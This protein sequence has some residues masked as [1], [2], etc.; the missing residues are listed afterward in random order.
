MGS[1]SLTAVFSNLIRIMQ[2]FT[3]A[4]GLT[5]YFVL[6]PT[7][8]RYPEYPDVVPIDAGFDPQKGIFCTGD[9]PVQEMR[10]VDGDVLTFAD[11]NKRNTERGKREEAVGGT[12]L[13]V[14][15]NAILMLLQRR[16]NR[17]TLRELQAVAKVSDEQIQSVEQWMLLK[18]FT[19]ARPNES[20]SEY[21]ENHPLEEVDNKH[22]RS[23]VREWITQK[24]PHNKQ[25]RVREAISSTLY[26][27]L[28]PHMQSM[29][30]GHDR[31][32]EYGE[33]EPPGY[34]HTCP[35]EYSSEEDGPPAKKKRKS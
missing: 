25:P 6:G 29:M 23:T 15:K 20:F 9:I 28:R 32:Y 12:S 10:L 11:L 33:M 19:E 34:E 27:L 3:A 18:A 14:H 17:Q 35:S 31:C 24:V 30:N 2:P 13:L 5:Y 1:E 16:I 21:L 22:V 8:T 7:P 26:A 4:N